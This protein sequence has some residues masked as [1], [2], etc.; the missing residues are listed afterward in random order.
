ML[1]TAC[2]RAQWFKVRCGW[3]RAKPT[4]TCDIGRLM[5]RQG[6]RHW[7]GYITEHEAG[8]KCRAWQPSRSPKV[9][10]DDWQ[11]LPITPSNPPHLPLSSFI[12]YF[13]SYI[14][15]FATNAFSVWSWPTGNFF[16]Y[17]EDYKTR[18]TISQGHFLSFFT[19]LFLI[20]SLV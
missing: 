20:F 10:T 17:D 18:Q 5:S 11:P 3:D 15:S 8:G 19:S 7:Q 1:E 2:L 16:S 12:S 4:R 13:L 9:P 6:D 14:L